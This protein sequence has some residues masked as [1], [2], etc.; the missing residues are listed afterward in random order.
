MNPWP[1]ESVDEVDRPA[2]EVPSYLMA[3]N[4]FIDEFA[5]RYGVPPEA[6]RGGAQTMYPEYMKKLK[7]MKLLPRPKPPQQEQT[8]PPQPTQPNK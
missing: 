1:C 6:T 3:Q 5:A 4:P 7:T 2:G 8:S